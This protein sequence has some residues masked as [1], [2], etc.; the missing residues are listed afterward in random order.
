GRDPSGWFWGEVRKWFK[1]RG[2]LAYH[3]RS[4]SLLPAHAGM[5]PRPLPLVDGRRA[6]PRARGDG[7]GEGPAGNPAGPCSPRTRGWSRA[8]LR[9][10]LD[11]MLLPAHA[12]MV[13]PA[14]ARPWPPTA[15]PRARGDGPWR[16]KRRRRPQ[17][18]SPRT[19]GWSLLAARLE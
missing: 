1:T 19:R 11:V 2:C 5:V 18:C 3:S 10:I 8:G 9:L 17:S 4:A 7:P 12:G 14:P 13:P 15:A 6:A 16:G